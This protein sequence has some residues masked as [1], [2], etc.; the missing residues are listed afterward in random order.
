MK[1]IRGIINNIFKDNE[2]KYAVIYNMH[3]EKACI[4]RICMH[5]IRGPVF[6]ARVSM[7]IEV[8]RV[9]TLKSAI[10][11]SGYSFISEDIRIGMNPYV[12]TRIRIRYEKELDNDASLTL[13]I[14]YNTGIS[15]KNGLIQGGL[16]IRIIPTRII[17]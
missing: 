6:L 16:V 9:N 17:G 12:G 14:E 4:D 11:G 2:V 7:P 10:I 5:N 13:T 1:R 8:S 3:D 15:L